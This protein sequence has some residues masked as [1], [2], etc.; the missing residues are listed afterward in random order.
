MQRYKGSFCHKIM[1]FRIFSL[2]LRENAVFNY[3]F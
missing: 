3:N 1:I 2:K